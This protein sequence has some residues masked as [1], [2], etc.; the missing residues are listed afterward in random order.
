[1]AS[2]N[3][4]T[5]DLNW[6]ALNATPHNLNMLEELVLEQEIVEALAKMLEDKALGPDGFMINLF[7]SCWTIIE[8]DILAVFQS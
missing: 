7:K 5:L 3:A 6:E 1:M 2:S 4:R 8:A